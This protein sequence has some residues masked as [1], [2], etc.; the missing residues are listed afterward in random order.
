MTTTLDVPVASYGGER[1]N[2]FRLVLAGLTDIWSRRRLARYLVQAELT[3]TGADTLLGN[4]WWI[5]DPLLQMGVY[6]VFVSLIVGRTTA[7]YPLFVFAAILP[8][9]WFSAAV[10]DA[11]QSVVS[12]ERIIKQVHFPKIILPVSATLSGIVHFAFGLIPLIL[13]MVL[14]Y[15]DRLAWTLLLIPA[16]AVVQFAFTLAVAILVAAVNVFFR[17]VGNVARHVLRLWFYLSPALYS[18][19]QV[20]AIAV[21]HP[22]ARIVFGLNPFTVLFEGYRAVIYDDRQPAWTGLLVL[23]AISVVLIGTSTYVFKRMEPSFAKVL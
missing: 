15:R 2:A 16:I 7:D 5:L 20:D 12:R 17:D 4:I 10:N 23:L 6:V 19:Q 11:I 1:P 8:W 21:H 14:F 13:L 18:V 22:E 3:K 9:K